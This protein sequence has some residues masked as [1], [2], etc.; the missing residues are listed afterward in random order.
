MN[1]PEK[2]ACVGCGA[3]ADACP[4]G[5]I[6]LIPDEE[7]FLYP[8]TDRELCLSCGACEAV[9]PVLEPPAPNDEPAAYAL[10]NNNA[11]E[12]RLSS[13]GGAFCLLAKAVLGRGG[14]VCGAAFNGDLSVSHRFIERE[15]EL[16]LLM[17]SKYVQSETLG[18]FEQTK[19]LLE[20]GREVLFSGTPCQAAALKKYLGREYTGLLMIDIVCHGVPSPL[21]WKKYLGAVSKGKRPVSATFRDKTHGWRGYSVTVKLEGGGEHSSRASEDLHMRPYLKGL[22]S[23]LSCYSCGFRGAQRVSDLTLADLWGAEVIPGVEDDDTGVSLVLVHTQKGQAA[24]DSVS[25]QAKLVSIP[26]TAALERNASA[27]R[28]PKMPAERAAYMAELSNAELPELVKKYCPGSTAAKLK[29]FVKK[30]LGK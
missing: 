10:I 26:L 28:S 12:R 27:L 16:P 1:L 22:I 17:G 9:C 30:I 24:F 29:R 13:S 20:S 2:A 3:C 7:G 25:G 8:N 23:R 21:H 18:V 11:S 14:A 15:D 5:C 6:K 19:R 4:V